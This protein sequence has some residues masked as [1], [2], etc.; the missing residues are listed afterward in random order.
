MEL[1]SDS[2]LFCKNFNT[3]SI[4]MKSNDN[5]KENNPRNPQGNQP[6]GT[7]SGHQ[8]QQPQQQQ[9]KKGPADPSKSGNPNRPAVNPQDNKYGSQKPG[10]NPQGNRDDRSKH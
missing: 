8:Q 2:V 10:N 5:N 6:R 1:Y 7:S 4:K 3:R 9:T